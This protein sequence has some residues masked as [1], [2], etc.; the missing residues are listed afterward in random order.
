MPKSPKDLFMVSV[1]VIFIFGPFA[2]ADQVPKDRFEKIQKLDLA[3][4]FGMKIISTDEWDIHSKNF[5]GSAGSLSCT[6]TKYGYAEPGKPTHLV[7]FEVRVKTSDIDRDIIEVSGTSAASSHLQKLGKIIVPLLHDHCGTDLD[8][9]VGYDFIDLNGKI[10]GFSYELKDGQIFV[11]EKGYKLNAD[12]RAK[13]TKRANLDHD[14]TWHTLYGGVSLL[15]P[16]QQKTQQALSERGILFYDDEFWKHVWSS[17]IRDVWVAIFNGEDVEGAENFPGFY[18][19]YL[20]EYA[21]A[22][23]EDSKEAGLKRFLTVQQG[24]LVKSETLYGVTTQSSVGIV[25]DVTEFKVRPEFYA[26]LK[27][28]SNIPRVNQ[29]LLHEEHVPSMEYSTLNTTRTD[30]RNF[31]HRNACDSGIV[32]QYGEN[33]RRIANRLP[34]VQKTASSSD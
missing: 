23:L 9:W 32:R 2:N 6:P 10:L 22:C 19:I 5:S 33:L 15:S 26:K 18:S 20:Q 12:K 31:F 13:L 11:S 28:Y 3:N 17:S 30:L 27:E 4:D 24:E 1:L 14:H 34:T 8:L 16:A 25:T 29:W 21:A 7:Y